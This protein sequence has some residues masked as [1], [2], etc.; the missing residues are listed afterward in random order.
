MYKCAFKNSKHLFVYLVVKA[1]PIH[2]NHITS[3]KR[4]IQLITHST[5]ILKKRIKIPIKISLTFRFHPKKWFSSISQST[6]KKIQFN[7]KKGFIIL[8]NSV[9]NQSKNHIRQNTT[10]LRQPDK[11]HKNP[12]YKSFYKSK[13]LQK[14]IPNNRI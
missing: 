4:P 9:V 8:I 11:N 10:I 1:M 7:F 13:I 6:P 5:Q 14:A 3:L 2:E 12:F